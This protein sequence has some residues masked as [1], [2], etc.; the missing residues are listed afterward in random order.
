M[1]ARKR[2]YARGKHVDNELAK[3]I[4]KTS[5]RA[6]EASPDSP[7]LEP[8]TKEQETYHRIISLWMGSLLFLENM[9]VTTIAASDNKEDLEWMN[10]F[11]KEFGER[12]RNRG[13]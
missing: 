4:I 7:H 6:R 5:V 11:F 2:G 13:R 9:A 8:K 10:E 12:E 3:V 1:Q